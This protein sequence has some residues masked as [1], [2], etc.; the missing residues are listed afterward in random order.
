MFQELL[1]TKNYC[2]T[3]VWQPRD[4][5][6]KFEA[7]SFRTM[8]K[9]LNN[10]SCTYP[11]GSGPN[12]STSLVL[13]SSPRTYHNLEDYL[14]IMSHP[15]AYAGYIENATPIQLYNIAINI[16]FSGSSLPSFPINSSHLHILYQPNS[17]CY[18][19]LLPLSND[20]NS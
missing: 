4:S 16:T 12:Q 18:S 3:S 19:S 20:V 17:M 9:T 15:N 2:T 8:H 1:P 7:K 10:T 13:N 11:T 14:Q 6:P 5:P